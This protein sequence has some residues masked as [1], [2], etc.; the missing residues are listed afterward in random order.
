MRWMRRLPLSSFTYE[1]IG[2]HRV[3]NGVLVTGSRGFV[4]GAQANVRAELT[5]FNARGRVR[6]SRIF[7]NRDAIGYSVAPLRDGSYAL[8][9]N[10]H[11]IQPG[12][13]VPRYYAYDHTIVK[14]TPGGDSLTQ[15]HVGEWGYHDEARKI[16]ATS[17]G[18]VAIVGWRNQPNNRPRQAVFVKLDS[19]LQEE[20]RYIIRGTSG[21]NGSGPEFTDA[22]E[23]VNGHFVLAGR[24]NGAYLLTDVGP[25]APGDTVAA[26]SWQWQPGIET[27]RMLYEANGTAYLSGRGQQPGTRGFDGAVQRI[28]GLPQAVAVDYCGR[29]PVLPLPTHGPLNGGATMDFALDSAAT[30]A[31]PRYA[32]VSLV[33]WE[34]GDG[35]PVD[36]GWV[37]R[38]TFASPTPVR[39]RVCATNNLFCRSCRELYPLGTNAEVLAPVVSVVPNP[40]ADGRYWVRAERQEPAEA[41]VRDALGRVVGRQRL[42][43]E[44]LVDLQG[45]PGGVYLLR[46]TW[47]NGR[48]VVRRL[49]R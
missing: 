3:P 20:W 42:S 29:P 40:S 5:Q 8:V 47:G 14:V 23:V 27:W 38:H 25:P 7:G 24:T 18:G 12:Q 31:G 28:S 33:T 2:L 17:D 1:T 44:G 15:V 10:Q 36:T 16:I 4:N 43:G 22:Q 39:V 6:W 11:R 45:Q 21:T 41:E 32:E 35:S 9:L 34:W 46:L 48:M 19:A 49:V 26:V 30:V 13:P 37:V